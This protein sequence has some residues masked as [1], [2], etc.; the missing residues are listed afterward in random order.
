M[1]AKSVTKVYAKHKLFAEQEWTRTRD[2]RVVKCFAE[3]GVL[4][5]KTDKYLIGSW[6]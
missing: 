1:K 2:L 6:M 3:I 5:A 4:V